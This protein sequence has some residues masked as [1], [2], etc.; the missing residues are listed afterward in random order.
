MRGVLALVVLFPAGRVHVHHDGL[1]TSTVSSKSNITVAG[2]A[3]GS[4][5]RSVNGSASGAESTVG[6]NRD[7]VRF[8]SSRVAGDT[9]TGVVIPIQNGR[10]TY[11]TAGT[12]VRSM[13]ATVTLSGQTPTT[14]SR[15]EVITF[16]G[17]STA[18]ITVTQD[19]TTKTGT[20]SLVGEGVNC[21]D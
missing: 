3:S 9:A 21:H 10:P 18:Q 4:T 19:G 20:L 5:Q 15:R 11:P 13:Q 14:S 1:D 6:T 2:L 16:D 8:T 17:T 7:G 12:I